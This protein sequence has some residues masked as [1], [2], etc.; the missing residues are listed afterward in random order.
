MT[1][2]KQKQARTLETQE[3]KT[4]PAPVIPTWR[5]FGLTI[6]RLPWFIYIAL[7]FLA[8]L[9]GSIAVVAASGVFNMHLGFI[10]EVSLCFTA[11]VFGV[12]GLSIRPSDSAGKKVT[13]QILFFI[14]VGAFAICKITL[15]IIGALIL[16]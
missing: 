4:T 16:P 13:P 2:R 7:A 8:A 12:A 10:D 6:Y 5:L 9:A 1:K 15:A 14:A 3:L 11:W